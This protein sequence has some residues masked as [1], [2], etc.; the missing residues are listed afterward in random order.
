MNKDLWQ[1]F[2]FDNIAFIQLELVSLAKKYLLLI[3]K[4]KKDISYV[5]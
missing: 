1:L 5:I 4:I 2:P 3:Y